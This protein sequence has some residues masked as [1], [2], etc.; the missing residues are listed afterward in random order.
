MGL[1]EGPEGVAECFNFLIDFRGVGCGAFWV[2]TGGQLVY[3]RFVALLDRIYNL[4]ALLFFS[5]FCEI[6]QLV[7]QIGHSGAR[8]NNN[9]GLAAHFLGDDGDCP[10]DCG[11]VPD[12]GPAKFHYYHRYL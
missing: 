2:D 4:L 9:H 1:G 8:G 5:S 11:G 7:Q 12:G 10:S 3:S 6:D